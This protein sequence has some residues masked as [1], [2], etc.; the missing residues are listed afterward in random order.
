M[1]AARNHHG[2]VY[3]LSLLSVGGGSTAKKAIRAEIQDK[4][5]QDVT[6]GGAGRPPVFPSH[7]SL[8]LRTSLHTEADLSRLGPAGQEIQ[9]IAVTG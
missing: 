3:C 7:P 5:M 4:E 9:C 2:C 6:T 8:L 1:W